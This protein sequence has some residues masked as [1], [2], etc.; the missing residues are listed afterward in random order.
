MK[1][2]TRFAIFWVALLTMLLGCSAR[3]Q[4]GI[5]L[6]SV[7]QL[8][9]KQTVGWEERLFAKR[10]ETARHVFADDQDAQEISAYLARRYLYASSKPHGSSPYTLKEAANPHLG[11]FVLV[12]LDGKSK[13]REPWV[14][15]LDR[16]EYILPFEADPYVAGLSLLEK[17]A[18]SDTWA[19]LQLIMAGRDLLRRVRL[20]SSQA[21]EP[22]ESYE[23]GAKRYG[24]HLA[25][26]SGGDGFA[27]AVDKE[28]KRI[29]ALLGSQDFVFSNVV[30]PGEYDGEMDKITAWEPA[31][32]D[33]E[34]ELRQLVV[35]YQA[36][37]EL[38]ERYFPPDIAMDQNIKF[39]ALSLK[40]LAPIRYHNVSKVEVK[41]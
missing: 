5:V 34:R 17:E 25:A 33:E 7:Q 18:Y 4:A 2:M 6:P 19:S 32:S 16:T 15:R 41:N 35:W 27:K 38:N 21:V 14:A 20:A 40:K 10:V 24:I 13:A 9:D 11:Y 37:F 30:P 36:N 31:K 1:A 12:I 22:L 8:M 28:K 39:V 29:Q 26:I 3:V 23:Y